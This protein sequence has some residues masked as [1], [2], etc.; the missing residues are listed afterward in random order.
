MIFTSITPVRAVVRAEAQAIS[1]TTQSLP[2]EVRTVGELLNQFTTLF[3]GV[4]T[5]WGNYIY[6]PFAIGDTPPISIDEVPYI[7][8]CNEK[9]GFYDVYGNQVYDTPYIDGVWVA[10]KFALYDIENN[11]MPIIFINYQ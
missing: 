10:T 3:T 8:W 5:R 1:A 7:L 4:A 6:A 9:N 2:R 11:G